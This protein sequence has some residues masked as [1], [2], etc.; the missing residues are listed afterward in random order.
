MNVPGNFIQPDTQPDYFVEFLEQLDSLG[1]IQDMRAAAARHINP[2]PGLTILDLGCGIGGA[3][4]VLSKHA[5][6]GGFVAGVDISAAL[7]DV[8]TRR[9]GDR[10]EIEFRVGDA[11]AIPYPDAYFDAAY[12][13]RVFLYLPD[14]LAVIRELQRVVKPGGTICLVDTDFDSTAIYSSRRELTRKLTT[15]VAAGIPNPNS[16]R[17]LPALAKRAGL[18]EIQV[19]TFAATTPYQFLVHA[20]GGPLT[21]AAER[22]AV[23]PADLDVWLEEQAT[24]HD[25]GDFFHA[26]MFVRVMAK[27][28]CAPARG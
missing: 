20:M 6:A 8:A 17:E 11:L 7:I 3:S 12:S 10:H 28:C 23:A 14:R 25:S 22:G 15:I 27:V 19:D 26:W 9:A 24:L 1:Q 18:E 2:V 13:E 4:F 21:R 16:A 5:G